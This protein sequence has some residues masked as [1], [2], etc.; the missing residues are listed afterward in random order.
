[1]PCS[2]RSAEIPEIPCFSDCPGVGLGALGL[3][4]GSRRHED[5]SSGVDS[6]FGILVCP[7]GAGAAVAV[8]KKFSAP[9]TVS[10]SRRVLPIMVGLARILT[11]QRKKLQ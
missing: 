9:Q 11:F 7:I 2:A 1:M 3:F 8:E 4:I 10:A 5:V 6:H